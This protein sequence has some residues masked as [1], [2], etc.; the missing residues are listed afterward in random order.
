MLF[1]NMSEKS[2]SSDADRGYTLMQLPDMRLLWSWK[3]NER[4]NP[5]PIPGFA[6]RGGHVTHPCEPPWN[7]T[8]TRGTFL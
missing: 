8:A 4:W 7:S 1:K 5:N 2:A 6:L 3:G